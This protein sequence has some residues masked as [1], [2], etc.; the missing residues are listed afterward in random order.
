ML[1]IGACTEDDISAIAVAEKAIRLP[2]GSPVTYVDHHLAHAA[3]AFYSSAFHDATIVVC[4]RG[5]SP[6]LTVWRGDE[7]GLRQE[8][9]GWSGPGFASV[10]SMAAEA[11]GFR[12]E[13]DEHRL[14]AL[15]RAGDNRCSAAIPA[16][17]Y[18]GDR[19]DVPAHFQAAIAAAIGTNGSSASTAERASLAGHIQREVGGLLLRLVSDISR[20]FGSDRLCLGG[21][22]FY[23]SYFTTLLA[24]SGL[25]AD[26]FVPANPGNAGIAVGAA[27]SIGGAGS[28][29]QRREPL[30]PFLGPEFSPRKSRP[31]W[32]T[33]SCRT[34]A[35]GMGRSSS[36][37]PPRSQKGSWWAGFRAGWSGPR[38]R[39]AIA[40]SWRVRS[41]PTC[42]KTSTRF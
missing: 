14:E 29:P 33:A 19:L 3:T 13:G 28:A 20:R 9:F 23:N 31:S 39:W 36:E 4:D 32:T 21:G 24:Q 5:G 41:R 1:Q 42:S 6:E 26:T 15:A 10:Y 2:P 37:R 7:R 8:D 11:M 16:I 25:Y 40:A 27:L 30:S 12:R 38:A 18:R 35:C 22:L 34:T 17:E